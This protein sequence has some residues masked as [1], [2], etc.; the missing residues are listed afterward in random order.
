MSRESREDLRGRPPCVGSVE[1]F[2]EVCGKGLERYAVARL[3]R[4]LGLVRIGVNH[5]TIFPGGRSSVPH[6]HSKDEEFVYVLQGRPTLWLDGEV[7]ELAP[8]DAVA[9]PAG[10]GAGHSFLNNSGSAVKL[11]IVGEHSEKDQVAYPLNPEQSHPRPWSSAP[12]RPLGPHDGK[13][14]LQR[15]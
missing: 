15:G 11:L 8:G 4:K 14:D 10:T 12:R 3:G 5:E 2:E 6:A 7:T 1:E 9:F 13:T